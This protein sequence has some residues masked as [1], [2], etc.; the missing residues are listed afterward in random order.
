MM[1]HR[2]T[3]PAFTLIE[4]LVVIA[5]IALLIGLL[6]TALGPSRE[7]AR[8]TK[9]MANMRSIGQAL[10][11]YADDFKGIEPHWSG[12]QLWEGDGTNGDDP[13]PGWTEL[14]REDVGTREVF[15]DPSRSRELAPFCYFL[16]A[17]FTYGQTHAANTSLDAA[18]VQ[19]P[20]EF[21]LAGDC[22]NPTL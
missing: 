16:Q 22:D 19:F 13:G 3:D 11:M 10:A 15:Q 17:R 8:L 20:T 14:L 9:C 7:A 4:L 18:K 2:K 1:R 6:L 21:V 12:W 5:I